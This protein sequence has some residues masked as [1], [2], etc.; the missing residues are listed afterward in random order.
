MSDLSEREHDVDFETALITQV[1]ET[2]AIKE[3]V[4][5][6]IT[7]DFMFGTTERAALIWLLDWYKNPDVGDT[8]S[9]EMY[10]SEFPNFEPVI[11][12]DSVIALCRKVR[13]KKLYSDMAEAVTHIAG[14]TEGDAFQGLEEIRRLT[15][16]LT[17]MH[18]VD[19]AVDVRDWLE[20]LKREYLLMKSGK[21]GLKGKP[22]PWET[23]NEATLG[24]QDSHVVVI[25]GRPKSYKTWIALSIMQGF[26]R[27]GSRTLIFSQE[28]GDLEMARRVVALDGGV[29]YSQFLRGELPEDIEADF[30]ENMEAFAESEPVVIDALSGMGDDIEL[31]LS[32]KIDDTGADSILI[33]GAHTL[34][35]DWK[36]LSQLTRTIKRVAKKKKVRII[37]TTHANKKGV[38]AQV[39]GAANDIAHS[40]SFFQDCDLALRIQC[41]IEDRK[42][43]QVTAWTAALRDGETCALVINVKLC[44]DITEKSRISMGGEG[45]DIDDEIA[46][47]ELDG[48]EDTRE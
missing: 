1:I 27:A 34:G 26:H 14:V 16:R 19:N 47:A 36:E 5:Q 37:V 13:E 12:D 44:E 21:T 32:Q 31:E 48:E 24:C 18:S 45:S 10:M 30:M 39:G 8:P 40:D 15:A 20:D 7:V 23:L 22:Y 3:L 4:A 6:K 42:K 46:D 17:S 43:K 28:L 25:Y 29:N 9:W 33:D 38:Q 11:I 35:R 2:K 41:D